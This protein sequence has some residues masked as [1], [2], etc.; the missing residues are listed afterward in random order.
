M[1]MFSGRSAAWLARLLGVQEVA[2]SNLAGPT[3]LSRI[4]SLE[5]RN[6][7]TH[8]TQNPAPF[9]GRE[10]STPS[11]STTSKRHGLCPALRH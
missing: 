6:W 2:S 7:Q 9:T 8:G 5:W 11:S 4:K 3:N 1:V 10:G